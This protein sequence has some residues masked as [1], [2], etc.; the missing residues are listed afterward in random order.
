MGV[1]SSLHMLAGASW[2][3]FTGLLSPKSRTK[4]VGED[5]GWVDKVDFTQEE[6]MRQLP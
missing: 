2:A 3:A 1:S 6:S 4:L 5:A